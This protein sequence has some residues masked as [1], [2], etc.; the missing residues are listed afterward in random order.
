MTTGDEKKGLF[1]THGQMQ[2]IGDSAYIFDMWLGDKE[3]ESQIKGH[4]KV[5]SL[6]S[7]IK[8]STCSLKTKKAI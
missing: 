6:L 3:A 4:S 8:K 5:S 2:S 7:A 1:R